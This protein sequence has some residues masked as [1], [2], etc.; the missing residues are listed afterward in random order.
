MKYALP[1]LLLAAMSA[2]GQDRAAKGPP[3]MVERL[4]KTLNGQD[5]PF[6]IIIQIY[7][8]PESAERFEK[9]TA[10]VARASRSDFGCLG[11]EFHRDLEKSGHYTLVEHWTGVAAL[12]KHLEQPHTKQIQAL[13]A[14]LATTPRTAEIFIPLSR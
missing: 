1:I 6:A 7:I 5:R 2:S 11:Y 10:D 13:F 4:E 14:E 9:A 12:K 3:S 8:A